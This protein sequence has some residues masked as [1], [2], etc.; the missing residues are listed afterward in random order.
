[1]EHR[2]WQRVF[3]RRHCIGSIF[4]FDAS[5]D[6][7]VSTIN[8][9]SSQVALSS[10]GT[11]LA[12]AAD[13]NDA[14]YETDRTVNVYSLPSGSVINSFPYSYNG[15]PLLNMSLSGSGAVLGETFSPNSGCVDDAIPTTGGGPIWCNTTSNVQAVRLSPDGTLIAASTVLGSSS[16]TN[17][18]KNG[19]L[20]TAVPGWA[21]GWL[22]NGR[23]LVNTYSNSVNYA[24]SV[25]YDPLGNA[26]GAVSLPDMQAIDVVTG[27]S[28][29]SPE[30]NTIVSLTTGATT[31]ISGNSSATRT[32]AVSGL[33]VIFASGSLVLA[34]PH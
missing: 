32:G 4:S 19:V 26:L 24:G 29:Y 14:Q 12:A 30:L 18:Y 17:L 15:T 8:F 9:P 13:A 22:D 2:G 1:L 21:V 34:Q 23:L 6:A 28:V 3:Q 31:W 16:T 10:S 25:I 20:A 5:N 33:Q 27:T 11:V 7:P